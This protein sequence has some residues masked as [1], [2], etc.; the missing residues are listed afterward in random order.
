MRTRTSFVVTG[1]WHWPHPAQ[2]RAAGLCRFGGAQPC[3]HRAR[4]SPVV[5]ARGDEITMKVIGEFTAAAVA[6]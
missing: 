5:L 2:G 6:K 4:Q 1:Q 3:R